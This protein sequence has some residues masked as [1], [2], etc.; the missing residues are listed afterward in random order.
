MKKLILDKDYKGIEQALSASLDLANEGIPYDA[1]NTAKTHPL[2]RICDG[3]FSGEYTDEEAVKMAEIFLENGAH[4]NGNGL[5]EKQDTPLIAAASLHADRVAFFY[6]EQGADINHAGCHGG[7]A[8]HWAAW[9]G[10]D[11]VVSRLVQEGADIHKKCIDF[12]ATPLFWAVHGLKN[13]GTTSVSGSL[14]CVKILIQ[15]GADKNI[16]NGDGKT[17]FDLLGDEDSELKEQLGR[18]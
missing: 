8:L 4:I 11:K 9:C 12:K 3:V 7:T 17:V 10:R 15:S 18:D 1:V 5:I 2:H 6:I 16:P 13:G 14:E